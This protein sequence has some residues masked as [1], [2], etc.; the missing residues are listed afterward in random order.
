MLSL[1]L[2]YRSCG[3]NIRCDTELSNI[4]GMKLS[5]ICQFAC[6]DPSLACLIQSSSLLANKGSTEESKGA[7]NGSCTSCIFNFPWMCRIN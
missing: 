1:M 5:D 7:V 2:P 3:K 6:I 4:M